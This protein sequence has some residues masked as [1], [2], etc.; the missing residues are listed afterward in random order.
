M[1]TGTRDVAGC[2]AGYA[3]RLHRIIGARHHVASP[4]GAWLLLAL[5]GPAS[6]GE[7]RA[8]LT[9]VLG[10]DV[11]AASRVAADLL[12][13]P[14]PLVA[15]A[16]AVWT[17]GG[18]DLSEEFRRWR[19]GLPPAVETGKLPNQAG[20]DAWAR[21]HTFGLIDRFPI[22]VAGVYLLL[23]SALATKVSWQVPF[24][25]APAAELGRA[26]AWSRQLSVV[27]RTPDPEH[28]RGHRQFIAVTPEAGDVAVQ[29]AAAQHGLVVYSVAAAPEVPAADVL[30]AAHGIG[31]ADAAGAQVRRRSLAE[32]P[33]GDGP[34]WQ[35]REETSARSPADLC[36]AVLPAWT[37]RSRHQLGH[38]D[39]GFQAAKNALAP[40]PDPWQASQAAMARYSRTG[41]E[42]AAV[43][44]FAVALAM[45][46]RTSRRVAELRFGH[47]YAVV[48][49]AT[50]G[51]GAG[52]TDQAGR[53]PW[54]GVPVFS[55]WVAEPEDAADDDAEGGEGAGQQR[56]LQPR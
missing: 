21:E 17:A 16:A 20:A 46:P 44:G 8:V 22:D 43:T 9:E 34:A 55:A 50:D 31:C 54:H 25:L 12:G 35:L 40:G 19:A 29:A 3:S 2:V 10:C 38:P 11:E 53:G 14:H 42:A 28:P 32:L 33:L 15:A 48:A 6:A 24:R 27:L 23:A 52:R 37:A 5:A 4:L 39:L 51:D 18:E 30:A 49:I 56:R 7:D 1:T 13:H 36:T 47:P 45:R 41:F 26:S